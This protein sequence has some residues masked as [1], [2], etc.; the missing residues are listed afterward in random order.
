MLPT[1]T[2]YGR[3][4]SF[5]E[6]CEIVNINPNVLYTLQ[7]LVFQGQHKHMK[8][9]RWEGWRAIRLFWGGI[10]AGGYNFM[11]VLRVYLPTHKITKYVQAIQV[12]RLTTSIDVASCNRFPHFVWICV[13]WKHIICRAEKICDLFCTC[14][15]IALYLDCSETARVQS[16]SLVHLLLKWIANGAVFSLIFT[17]SESHLIALPLTKTA[18]PRALL[19]PLQSISVSATFTHFCRACLVQLQI[20]RLLLESLHP[21]GKCFPSAA[22]F[23]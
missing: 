2:S 3:S 5:S 11:S 23:Q 20:H 22:L 19:I 1:H 8:N 9:T 15:R 13:N 18:V 16:G 21:C 4:C 12:W 7:P 6:E 17:F 14:C 10:L